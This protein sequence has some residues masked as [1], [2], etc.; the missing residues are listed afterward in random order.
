MVKKLLYGIGFLFLVSLAGT[1]F[2][3]RSLVKDAEEGK[4]ILVQQELK[5]RSLEKGTPW[6]D[7]YLKV[8]EHLSVVGAGKMS[9]REI[10]D[11]AQVI[12]EECAANK[13]IGLTEDKIFALIE[14]ESGFD[15]KALSVAN[16]YGLT[17]CLE[18]V[19][20]LYL[21]SMGFPKFSKHLAYNPVINAK[22]GIEELKRLRRM[23]LSEGID[24]WE[25]AFTSYYWGERATWSI[26]AGRREKPDFDYGKGVIRLMEK[27]REKL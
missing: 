3:V 11:V 2:V 13:E 16:A 17:Q 12:C 15:P 21:P 10:V 14:M 23:W 25:V 20:D 9:S 22:V 26:I 1:I 19:F 27:W 24:S 18:Y 6:M 8:V 7:R 4:R 5:I